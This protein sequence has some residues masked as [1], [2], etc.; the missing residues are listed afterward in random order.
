MEIRDK[1]KRPRR[2]D[3]TTLSLGSLTRLDIW[4]RQLTSNKRG[5]QVT[6]KDLVNWA[7]LNRADKLTAEEVHQ[8]TS[9]F[10]NEVKFLQETLNEIRQA[11]A[12]GEAVA[13]DSLLTQISRPKPRRVRTPKQ[14]AKAEG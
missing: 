2:P 14:S 8:L 5:V 11:K 9:Q 1:K 4:I 7:I 13:L 12:K 3:R 6:S 10:L